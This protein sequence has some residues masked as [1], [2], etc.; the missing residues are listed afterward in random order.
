[1]RAVATGQ[2][3]QF[4][5]QLTL[6]FEAASVPRARRR[7]SDELAAHAVP[8]ERR[9]DA[10]LIVSELVGNALRHARP[11][12]DGNLAVSW[13]WRPD[14]LEIRV[15]DGGG[16][17]RPRTQH[18]SLSSIGGRGLEIVSGLAKR[19][20]TEDGGQGVCVYAVIAATA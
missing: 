4:S 14:E 11:Q 9:E 13:I 20:G 2:E 10:L 5:A 12:P 15:A 7:L 16:S 19:W 3:T 18:P 1:M 6:P 17:T 8:D